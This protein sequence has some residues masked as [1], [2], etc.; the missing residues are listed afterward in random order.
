V[1]ESAARGLGRRGAR[2]RTDA[3]QRLVNPNGGFFRHIA[4]AGQKNLYLGGPKPET[5]GVALGGSGGGGSGGGGGFQL[6]SML[7]R[8]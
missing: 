7:Q 4:F 6:P 2:M 1:V 5:A 3:D 8:F